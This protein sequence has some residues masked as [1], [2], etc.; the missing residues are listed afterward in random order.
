MQTSEVKNIDKMVTNLFN[1]VDNADL[2]LTDSS[3]VTKHSVVKEL[4]QQTEKIVA[5][6]EKLN[7]DNNQASKSI[8]RTSK[9]SSAKKR[10]TAKLTMK[11]VRENMSEEGKQKEVENNKIYKKKLRARK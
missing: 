10:E 1:V 3:Q 6:K 11:N 5:V 9:F 4:F 7:C 2:T 8:K